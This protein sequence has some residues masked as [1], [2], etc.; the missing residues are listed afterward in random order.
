MSESDPV[1][2]R[3]MVLLGAG[4][5]APAGIPTAVEMTRKTAAL[6]EDTTLRRAFNVVAGGIQMGAGWDALLGTDWQVD[7]ESVMNAAQLLAN[8]FDAEL[9]P[10]VGTWHPVLEELEHQ[11]FRTF[12]RTSLR[13]PPDRLPTTIAGRIDA[14]DLANRVLRQ[15]YEAFN[16]LREFLGRRPDGSLFVRLR[17]QLTQNLVKLTFLEDASSVTYLG[18]L[19]KAAEA[20]RMPVATLNY[21]NS[22]ELAADTF[23]VAYDRGI[24]GSEFVSTLQRDGDARRAGNCFPYLK[25]HGS[26]DWFWKK[27]HLPRDKVPA[28]M[29]KTEF[30]QVP[31]AEMKDAKRRDSVTVNR[32]SEDLVVVFGG[33]NKLTAEG[34]FLDLLFWFKSELARCAQLIVIGYS[35]RDEHI[36]HFIVSWFKAD[37]SRR[38]TVVSINP[39]LER[40]PLFAKLPPPD[41]KRVTIHHTRAEEA[42]P[43]LFPS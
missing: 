40:A 21:D 23:G 13:S 30:R 24:S 1:A 5:S 10:F 16:G 42:I 3:R 26:V 32:F 22:V 25:L 7:I 18:P 27:L 14:G 2:P 19:I 33:K 6:L 12:G 29:I 31:V 39:D 9:A 36:N 38:M 37:A 8:R 11:E 34:P 17:E 35:F 15:N 4:A 43:M 41:R 20:G 28:H